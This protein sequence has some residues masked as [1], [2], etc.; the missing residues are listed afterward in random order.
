MTAEAT[1]RSRSMMISLL[2][3]LALFLALFFLAMHINIP[4]FP[5]EGGGSGGVL[6]NVGYVDLSSGAVQPLSSSTSIEPQP[7][8]DESSVQ[9]S[10][11][12]IATQDVENSAAVTSAEKP[13]KPVIK[14]TTPVVT[15]KK[16]TEKPKTA[17]PRALYK[18]KTN[19]SSSQGTSSSGSGDQGNPQG[20]PNSKYY[21]NNGSGT[22][23]GNGT[24]TGTGTGPGNGPSFNLSGRKLLQSPPIHDSSQ[25]TG[26]LWC[27]LLLTNREM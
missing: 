10:K 18:G 13:K 9:D 27:R 24:G 12:K 23:P 21:G 22:G 5:E 19:N 11:E 26:K 3:H 6:V 8:N 2:V 14:K 20:D 17:D 25:E 7:V 1:I 16:E 4:P 15:P